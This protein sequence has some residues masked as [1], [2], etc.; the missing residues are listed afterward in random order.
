[1]PVTMQCSHTMRCV[2]ALQTDVSDMAGVMAIFLALESSWQLLCFEHGNQNGRCSQGIDFTLNV[3]VEFLPLTT[4][5]DPKLLA[6]DPVNHPDR[7]A[8]AAAPRTA[9]NNAVAI[10]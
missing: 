1:M 4:G 10:G 8:G 2:R 6:T 3:L 5:A 9:L 7:M